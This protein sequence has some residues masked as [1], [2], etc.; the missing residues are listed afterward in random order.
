[1]IPVDK[2]EIEQAW[3]GNSSAAA[4]ATNVVEIPRKGSTLTYKQSI[5]PDLKHPPASIIPPLLVQAAV[6]SDSFFKNSNGVYIG[7]CY[8]GAYSNPA[9]DSSLAYISRKFGFS[10]AEGKPDHSKEYKLNQSNASGES[11]LTR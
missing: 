5:K 10:V 1:M 2:R 11:I 7:C 4:S 3:V 8:R 6:P 9:P